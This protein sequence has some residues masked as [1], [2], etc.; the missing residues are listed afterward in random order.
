MD[1]TIQ[2]RV[3]S[4]EGEHAKPYAPYGKACLNCAKSKTRCAS[5]TSGGKC[6][7]CHRL[8]K[9]CQAAPAVRKKRVSKRVASSTS[10]NTAALEEKLEGIVQLLQR[11]QSSIPGIQHMES[12][13]RNESLDLGVIDSR[14]LS[15]S[16]V[17]AADQISHGDGNLPHNP[18]YG[19][20]FEVDDCS[21][22]HCRGLD[23]LAQK[24]GQSG[25]SKVG[26]EGSILFPV[27]GPPTPATSSAA[28]STAPD[29]PEISANYPL[30]SEAEL[31][32]CLEIYQ[33]KMLPCFPIIYISADTTVAELREERPFLFLVIR[34][35]CSKNLERQTALILHIKKVLGREILVEGTK[36]LDLLCGILVFAAWCHVY[37]CN[38]PINSALIHLAISL[39][40][41]LGIT[42]PIPGESVRILLNYT[43][44]GCPKPMN[45]MKMERTAEERRAVVGLFLT[46]SIFANFFQRI[47][48][49]HWTRY[50]QECLHILEEEKDCPT[51]DFLVHLVRVQLICNKG[52]A[53]GW[54]DVLGD[55]DV[56]VPTDLYVKTLKLQLEDLEHSIPQELKSNA[57]LQLHIFNTTLTLHEHSLSATLKP[58]SPDPTIQLQRIENLWICLNAV[59]SWFETF[60][61]LSESS[62]ISYI[63]F[64]ASTI[65]QMGHCLMALF[66]LST[67]EAPEVAWDCQR[68][69]REIDLGEVIKRIIDSWEQVPQVA[70]ME[71]CSVGNSGNAQAPN[72]PCHYATK[73]LH[74]VRSCWDAKITAMAAEDAE[75]NCGSGVRNDGIVNEFGSQQVDSGILVP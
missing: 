61:S 48:P 72:G 69:R 63:H 62:P 19:S 59:K 56:G 38:K 15:S 39:A 17:R 75:G 9:E 24:L 64:P 29:Q 36:N 22:M 14:T 52:S 55:A 21:L 13:L 40:F 16:G 73:V 25:P 34:A 8:N 74:V 37:G 70:G 65:S 12:Q 46:S 23:N 47:E 32:E 50:L 54:S 4:L 68:V 66:R 51:D 5:S 71:M 18:G 6:E 60:F 20:S 41:E 26:H 1:S 42:R 67:L 43:A 49:M 28:N 33:T 11:S 27:N 10:A 7:R 31:D 30:E 3:S 57:I 53:L 45:G 2:Q 35:I 44:Q 58:P